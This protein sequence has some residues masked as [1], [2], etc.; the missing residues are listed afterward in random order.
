MGIFERVNKI[1]LHRLSRTEATSHMVPSQIMDVERGVQVKENRVKFHSRS[2]VYVRR[3]SIESKGVG[4]VT[5]LRSVLH[6]LLFASR[7]SY[8]SL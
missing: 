4:V 1:P 6:S 3:C 7:D 5:R 2:V 8:K